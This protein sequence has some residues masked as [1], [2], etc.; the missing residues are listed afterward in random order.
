MH[1]VAR[2]ST[3]IVHLLRTEV[4]TIL[5]VNIVWGPITD[6]VARFQSF[7]LEFSALLPPFESFSSN[8]N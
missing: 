6:G 1:P 8:F 5:I 7:I 2:V 4:S 3:N